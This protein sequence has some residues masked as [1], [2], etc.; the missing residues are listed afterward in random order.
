MSSVETFYEIS[1]NQP[2]ADFNV[3]CSIINM[4]PRRFF[5]RI[6][7]DN[8][9]LFSQE[10]SQMFSHLFSQMFFFSQPV[11]VCPP[12]ISCRSDS[13]IGDTFLSRVFWWYFS[14][15]R[16]LVI[17][18]FLAMLVILFFLAY[19][20]FQIPQYNQGRRTFSEIILNILVLRRRL[21]SMLLLVLTGAIYAL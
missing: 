3:Q 5:P 7:L 13:D 19:L 18:F 10:F 1:P 14:F 8:S 12:H 11:D 15:S 9:Q 16:I 2:F 6:F 4:L 17:L 20:Q 21:L